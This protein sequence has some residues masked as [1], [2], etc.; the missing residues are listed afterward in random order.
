[1]FRFVLL[2]LLLIGAMVFVDLPSSYVF[3]ETIV[4][5]VKKDKP[6]KNKL[7]EDKL[8]R[9]FDSGD[10]MRDLQSKSMRS[11]KAVYGHWGNQADRFS[12]WLNHSNRLIPVYTFGIKLDSLR[13]RGS[14]YSDPDRLKKLY[15][16]VP[17]ATVNP[18]AAYFDQTDLHRLQWEAIQSGR[19]NIIVIIFDGLD[20][21][22]TRA[23]AIFKNGRVDYDQG[24]GNGLAFQ[25]E[26]RTVTDFGLVVTSS[27]AGGAKTDVNAQTVISC[28]PNTK[29]G[30][31]VDRGGDDP[32]HEQADRNYLM[33]LDRERPHN[34][35]DSAASATSITTGMKTYSGAINVAP[36][37]TKLIPIAR[38]L[39]ADKNMSIGVVTSVPVSHATPAAAYANNVTRKDYQDIA[40]DLLGLPS[41]SH[42]EEPL[43][44]VDVLIGGGWGEGIKDDSSQGDNFAS[45]NLYL[46]QDDVRKADVEN[47]GKYFVVQRSEGRSGKEDLAFASVAVSA[48]RQL[49]RSTRLLGFFGTKNGHL[50]FQTADG[51]YTPTFDVAGTERYTKADVDENPTLADMTTAALSVLEKNP[52]GFWLMIESG[53]VDWANHAN[54]LDNSIGAT[55]SGEAAFESVMDWIADKDAWDET[56]VIVTA[57]H[58]HYLV[59]DH[60]QVIAE[61]GRKTN[62]ARI[63]Q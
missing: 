7:K 34:V 31:D 29:G 58:G 57:D 13:K 18:K 50:P 46:H 61:A 63:S 47:G 36:D 3:A 41:S 2:G 22:T 39:Q 4:E 17:E 21:Q 54:N 24:R 28:T 15:G 44:G 60:P 26:R 19:T 30:Y 62:E 9:K 52:A 32:W 49:G 33:G 16:S 10:A 38:K 51:D 20:W 55:L 59:L 56:A 48:M 23:A 35:T 25:D 45:G 43:P 14:I 8:E 37:G 1:M 27:Y 42:R 5:P 12:N 40:R 6:K 11:Q 53:D